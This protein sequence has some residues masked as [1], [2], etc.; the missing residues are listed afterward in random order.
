MKYSI[1]KNA[2]GKLI[3]FFQCPVCSE[4][5][6]DSLAKAGSQDTCPACQNAFIVPG[7]AEKERIAQEKAEADLVHQQRKA[8]AA[9][10]HEK[11]RKERKEQAELRRK[12]EEERQRETDQAW[13]AAHAHVSQPAAPSAT[14][15]TQDYLFARGLILWYKVIGQVG[16][17]IGAILASVSVLGCLAALENVTTLVWALPLLGV[18]LGVMAGGIITMGFGELMQAMIDMAVNSKTALQ[19]LDEI[20]GALKPGNGSEK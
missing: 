8:E 7:T 14:S 20:S 9:E 15:H 10:R 12:Q 18:S 16:I 2:L 11:E 3:V 17:A 5:L 4:S 6:K 19:K 13:V 1:K